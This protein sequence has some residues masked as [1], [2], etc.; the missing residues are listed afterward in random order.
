MTLAE[1]MEA[2]ADALEPLAGEIAGLQVYPFL[3]TN[4]TPPSIDIYP[5]APFQTGAG[6]GVGN[7]AGVLHRPGP[8]VDRRSGGRRAGCCSRMLDPTDP[9]S[10]EAAIDEHRRGRA[11]RRVASSASTRG[12]RH[13]R[14]AGRLRME[15]ERVPMTNDLQG[16]GPTGFRGHEEGEEFDADLT[17]DRGAP[18]EGAR[19]DP[20]RETRRQPHEGEGE[21]RWLSASPSKTSVS[22]DAVDLSNFARAVEFTSRARARR[23]V[24]VQ[25]DRRERVPG[26]PDRAGR[27]PSSSTASYGTGEVH[28]TLYPIHQDREVVAFAWRPDQTAAV[29]ATN[30]ELRGNVQLLHLLRRAATRGEVDTFTVTF[31]AADED[32][33]AFVTAPAA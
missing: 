18:G 4:P 9:A 11:R 10:V 3:N 23:R 13:Q 6:F 7:S 26:R 19:L 20:G 15:S 27:R 31:N 12:H 32:G 2:I 21:G 33:L 8:G 24:R 30:P 5:G 29:S 14:P 25:R 17:E 22:V 16:D 28:A 1:T